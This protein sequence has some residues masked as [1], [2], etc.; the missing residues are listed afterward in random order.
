MTFSRSSLTLLLSFLAFGLSANGQGDD[1]Q[2]AFEEGN[3]LIEEGIYDQAVKE[4]KKCADIQPKNANVNY[5]VGFCYIKSGKHKAEALPY[6]SKAVKG[7]T[8]RYN[9]YSAREDKAPPKARYYFG[10]A[11]HLNMLMDSAIS[12]YQRFK[13][14]VPKGHIL[15]KDADRQIEMCKFAKKQVRDRKD[16]KIR[17]MGEPINTQYHEYGPVISVDENVMYFTSRRPPKNVS[18]PPLETD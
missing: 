1:F 7:I 12:V 9:P 3:K 14:N 16:V 2:S 8:S 15:Y 6:L 17:N 5:K 11:L 13:E 4:F 10:R 18:K